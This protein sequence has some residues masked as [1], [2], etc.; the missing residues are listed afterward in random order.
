MFSGPE[1]SIRRESFRL[2]STPLS[3]MRPEWG[4][5]GISFETFPE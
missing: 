2:G 4:N 5:D 3:T 1:E